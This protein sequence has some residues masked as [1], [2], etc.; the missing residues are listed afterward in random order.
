M[1]GAKRE[2]LDGSIY[3]LQP[4]LNHTDDPQYRRGGW[5]IGTGMLESTTRE[6]V[7]LRLKGPDMHWGPYGATAMTAPRAQDLNG[8]WPAFRKSRTFAN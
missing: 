5:Q 4:K 7:G 6:L 3:S 2:A 8:C 1:R